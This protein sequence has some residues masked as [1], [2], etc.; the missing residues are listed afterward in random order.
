MPTE[1]EIYWPGSF[2][3]LHDFMFEWGW[4]AQPV[5]DLWVNL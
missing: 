2:P 1:Y 4:A 3:V 5:Q